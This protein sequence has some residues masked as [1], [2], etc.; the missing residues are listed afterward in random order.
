MTD[1]VLCLLADYFNT[2]CPEGGNQSRSEPTLSDQLQLR[3][4]F[5]HPIWAALWSAARSWKTTESSAVIHI[6]SA[7]YE[8]PYEMVKRGRK[9]KVEP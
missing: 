4:P 2:E 3:M 1:V 6:L 7:H 9:P 5:A 8:L